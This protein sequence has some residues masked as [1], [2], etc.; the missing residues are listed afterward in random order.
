M[1]RY[2]NL[3]DLS[4]IGP[5]AR[6]SWVKGGPEAR[7]VEGL[8]LDEQLLAELNI[9]FWILEVFLVQGSTAA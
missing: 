1:S 9:L 4:T 5:I 8:A 6:K 7:D 3:V 2:S